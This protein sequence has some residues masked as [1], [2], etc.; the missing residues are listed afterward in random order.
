M[1]VS[2][3]P[4]PKTLIISPSPDQLAP[5]LCL[6]P[7]LAQQF[8]VNQVTEN[9]LKMIGL[10]LWQAINVEME[11]ELTPLNLMVDSDSAT[12]QS[13]PWECLYHPKLGFLGKHPNYTLSR[14]LGRETEFFQTS[15]IP[16]GPLN[17]LLF[18]AQPDERQRVSL[19]LEFEQQAVRRT[20][21]P[22]IN[23]GWVQLYAPDDGRFATLVELL[24]SHVWQVVLL[25]GHSFLKESLPQSTEAWLV[26]ESD[27]GKGETV[28]TSRLAEAFKE[29]QVQCVVIA[30]CQSGKFLATARE[31][32][33]ALA[34]AQ[35][36]VPH[37]V[38]M[39]EPLVDR[40]G[41][42][43]VQAFCIALAQQT[44]VDV[45]VQ[46]GRRAMLN[47]LNHNEVWRD[48]QGPGSVD[49]SVG[50]WCLPLLLT[51]DPAQPLVDWNFG[52]QPR[53]PRVWRS[54]QRDL[55]GFQNLQ[56][57]QSDVFIGRRRE[58]RTL[59][60]ALRRGTIRRLL[61]RGAGGVGKTALA[62]RLV[63]T[64][65]EQRYRVLIYQAS[66]KRSFH[67]ILAQLLNMPEDMSLEQLIE[68]L[69]KE[70]WVVWLDDWYCGEMNRAE[71]NTWF[72]SLCRGGDNLRV[73]LTS[74]VT[75]P[76]GQKN[77]L[78]RH[79]KDFYDYSLTPPDYND[80]WRYTQHLGLPHPSLQIRLM[81][82]VLKGN[83][84]GVQ[85]LQSLPLC[86]E[87]VGFRKQLAIV[88]RYLDAIF[89]SAPY[90]T[91]ESS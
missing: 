44:R 80:F 71:D 61:I 1:N 57:L 90:C 64:L 15:Q 84:K 7:Q 17:I 34:I 2:T 33:L 76:L 59:G 75:V 4:H 27:A 10:A 89:R 31:A 37:V 50:Q 29:S 54:K 38:G 91:P 43:F 6:A 23:E 73:L 40:A 85:L 11:E 25:S 12:V 35:A 30:T 22:W 67:A 63:T 53:S 83:F 56:E 70:P 51:R 13:L 32:N 55:E 18:T 20:L 72:E 69:T 79:L 8:A 9:D 28:A 19:E 62:R 5:L 87:G 66:E 58:L 74:R 81:Y 68:Q 39:R 86:T 60:E 46:Q 16:K 52:P 3:W 24:Q 21:E 77:S 14:R 78:Y 47:L 82:K 88:Q 65:T 41:S 42:V 36:G 48:I 26:F 49:P 45:A